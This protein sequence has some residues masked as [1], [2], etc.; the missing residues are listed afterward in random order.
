V[1]RPALRTAKATWSA[2]TPLTRRLISRR[3][4][5]LPWPWVK[6][7]RGDVATSRW[8]LALAQRAA[9]GLLR[10]GASLVTAAVP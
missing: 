5:L 7:Q 3:R 4:R 10:A 2:C 8:L 9:R 1:L 6:Q